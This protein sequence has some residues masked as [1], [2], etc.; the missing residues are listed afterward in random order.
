MTET[1]H[2]NFFFQK[3]SD[4][5]EDAVP[6][7]AAPL[8]PRSRSRRMRCPPPHAGVARR[9]PAARWMRLIFDV[10]LHIGYIGSKSWERRCSTA[11]VHFYKMLNGF[12]DTLWY[13]HLGPAAS[14]R[15]HTTHTTQGGVPWSAVAQEAAGFSSPLAWRSILFLHHQPGGRARPRA[16][17]RRHS[18]G[19]SPKK[20][21]TLFPRAFVA[22]SKSGLFLGLW[23]VLRR[24]PPHRYVRSPYPCPYHIIPNGVSSLSPLVSSS[25]RTATRATS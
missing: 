6:A 25:L 7:S 20:W 5:A 18:P 11:V 12:A 22:R 9:L 17:V 3:N 10:G 19:A 2:A 13:P 16:G 14:W 15:V 8:P 21:P 24:R 1:L 23:G 4:R